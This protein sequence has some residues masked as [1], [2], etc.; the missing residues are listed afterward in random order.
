MDMEFLNNVKEKA[1]DLA[2]AGVAQSK[3]LVE[4]AKLKTSI[5]FGYTVYSQRLRVR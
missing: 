2:Q 4:I 5:V 1:T 3:R